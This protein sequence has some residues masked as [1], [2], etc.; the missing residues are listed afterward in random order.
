M[1]RQ[2]KK[3]DVAAL[4]KIHYHELQSD[5]LPSLGEPFLRLL[6]ESFLQ[7]ADVNILVIE[8]DH[9]VRGFVIGSR[10]FN[11]V[12][13]KI[14]LR[15]FVKFALL[16]IPHI[17]QKPVILKNVFETFLYPKKES[18]VVSD[19]ELIVI[20]ISKK[21]HRKGFGKKLIHALEKS[22]TTQKV[23]QYKLTVNKNNMAANAFYN[24]LGF[25]KNH[26]FFLYGKKLILYTKHI[27]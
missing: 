16:I 7:N 6:Y 3:T 2:G 13:K 19:A 14:V 8:S 26:E 15:N 12:F 23:Y 22:F 4:V 18:P 21:Y 17:F 20:A 24:T 27:Q 5:F 10:N 9:K 11:R 1:L 25:K